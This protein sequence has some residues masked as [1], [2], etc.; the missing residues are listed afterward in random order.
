M[1]S[2]NADSMDATR[3][4]ALYAEKY[5]TDFGAHSQKA[6]SNFNMRLNLGEKVTLKGQ[7]AEISSQLFQA[8]YLREAL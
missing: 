7:Q 2:W 5:G 6:D 8:L 4:A 1:W 3:Q